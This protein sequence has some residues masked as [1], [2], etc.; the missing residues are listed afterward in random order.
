MGTTIPP[1]ASASTHWYS[2]V[3]HFFKHI[4]VTV[5]TAFVLL[6]GIDAA[7]TFAVGAS[8]LLKTDLGKIAMVAVE[9]AESLSTGAEKRSAAFAKI[10]AAM[11]AQGLNA[12]DSLVNMLIELA[13]GRLKGIFK[14][15]G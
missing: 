4:G 12:K 13:V 9:E 3:L 7:H 14:Y 15:E 5:S 10:V 11:K 1:T 2:S 6:F 8:G